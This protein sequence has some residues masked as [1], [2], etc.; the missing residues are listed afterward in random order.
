MVSFKNWHAALCFVNIR[1]KPE[2]GNNLVH[3]YLSFKPSLF[4]SAIIAFS[5]FNLVFFK[6]LLCPYRSMDIELN[7]WQKTTMR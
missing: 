7:Y 3:Q 1:L 5:L 6:L 4:P 2:S